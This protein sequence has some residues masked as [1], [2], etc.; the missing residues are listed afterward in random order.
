LNSVFTTAKSSSAKL[1]DKVISEF[2]SGD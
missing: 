2:R 1:N